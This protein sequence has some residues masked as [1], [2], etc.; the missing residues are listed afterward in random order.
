[1][2]KKDI[3]ILDVRYLPGPS[4]WTYTPIIEAVV[5]IHDLEDF[6]SNKIPGFPERLVA[7][8]P[9]L[10]EH[11][12]SPG[13]YGGFVSRL[14]EGTWPGHI[15]EH[16]TIELQNLAG[17]KVTFGK[18]RE[19]TRRSLYKVVFNTLHEQIGRRALVLARELVLAAMED[20]PFDVQAAVAELADMAFDLCLG[21]STHCIVEAAS[22]RKI[23]HIRL[24][25]EGNLVQ[26]GYGAA[27]RRIWTAE[28]DG[29]SAIAEGIAS[30]KDLTKQLLGYCGVPTPEG[31]IVES[32][33]EA[34]EAAQDIGAPEIAVV[35]KPSD[36]NRGRG[37]STDLTTQADIEAAYKIA[38]EEGSEVI[39]ERFVDG[40]EHRLLVIGG[41]LVAAARGEEASVTGD[42][43]STV[44][45]LID[46][47]INNDPRRGTASEQPLELIDIERKP[48]IVLQLQRQGYTPE[49]VPPAGQRVVVLRTGNHTHDVTHLVHPDVAAAAVLAAK[50]VGLDIAGVDVVAQDI[51]QPLETQGGAIVEV[52]AGPSLLMHLKP[53]VG[54]PQPVGEA[55]VESLFPKLANGRIPVVGVS[56]SKGKSRVAGMV[57]RLLRLSGKYVGLAISQGVYV[58]RRK[59]QTT[60]AA[61][62]A[63][64]ERVLLNRSVNAAV[65]EQGPFSILTEGLA[66]DR[67]DVGIV[68]NLEYKPGLAEYHIHDDDQL[69]NVLRTQVDVVLPSGTAVLNADDAKIAAMAELC[70]GEVIFFSLRADNEI[71]REHRAKGGRAVFIRDAWIVLAKGGDEKSLTETRNIPLIADQPDSVQVG[72]VLAAISAAWALDIDT[73]LIKSNAQS[74]GSPD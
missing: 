11:T 55:I 71:I 58:N 13:V 21:P 60:D 32:A 42:G 34:W 74:F 20:K 30:E 24:L 36:G 48:Q 22:K 5:D 19:V 51:T 72:N 2:S 38:E 12:C 8:L 40:I 3:E 1:M 43:K 15:L 29:T 6:P 49:S 28:T 46:N 45:E 39:V 31:R 18:A 57:A 17:M 73:A 62:Y 4:M 68:T 52:N 67:C 44:R 37:V 65:I 25:A 56:G 64:G 47:Q 26:L 7:W 27:Q 66:Y 41:K 63:G 10:M 14:H 23:P 35:V 50:I 9:S 59:L 61:N 54:E 53:A 16:I 70:D 33:V 69:F